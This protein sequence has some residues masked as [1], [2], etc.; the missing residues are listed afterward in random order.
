[1]AVRL[2]LAHGVIRHEAQDSTRGK[3]TCPLIRMHVL[4][5]LTPGLIDSPP[6]LPVKELG[7]GRVVRE[8]SLMAITLLTSLLG[9]PYGRAAEDAHSVHLHQAAEAKVGV[10]QYD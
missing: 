8:A 7:G 3:W 5:A 6:P 9:R 2:M 1:M 4:H 10:G